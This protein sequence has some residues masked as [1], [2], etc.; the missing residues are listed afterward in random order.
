MTFCEG[1]F[2]EEKGPRKLSR[3]DGWALVGIALS[4]NEREP[5]W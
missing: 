5:A 1:P 4:K 3:V 2:K